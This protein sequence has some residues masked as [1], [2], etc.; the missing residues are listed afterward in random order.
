MDD[1]CIQ[2]ARRIDVPQQ[3]GKRF[4][5]GQL[6]RADVH[7]AEAV[8]A[9]IRGIQINCVG[10]LKVVAETFVDDQLGSFKV[11]RHHI[12]K[13]A[14]AGGSGGGVQEEK[15]RVQDNM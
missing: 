3:N 11:H 4:R 7:G 12:C 9:G 8:A 13:E 10:N 5:W 1:V 6:L 14:R 15:R 2:I